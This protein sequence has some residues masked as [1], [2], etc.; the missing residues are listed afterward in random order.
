M[1][2]MVAQ[3]P[4]NSMSQQFTVYVLNIPGDKDLNIHLRPKIIQSIGCFF[5]RTFESLCLSDCRDFF[6]SVCIMLSP[7]GPGK[8]EHQIAIGMIKTKE[9]AHL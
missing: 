3:L 7:T 5:W 1:R 8:S 2:F 9:Y 6:F 4:C